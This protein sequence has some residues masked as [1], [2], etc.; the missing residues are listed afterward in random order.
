MNNSAR[1]AALTC[2][3]R[4]FPHRT[5]LWGVV[6]GCTEGPE[7]A[8][9]R[10]S[11]SQLQHHTAA[12]VSEEAHTHMPVILTS[13][14]HS[15]LFSCCDLPRVCAFAVH[16]NSLWKHESGSC[17]RCTCLIYNSSVQGFYTCTYLYKTSCF[18]GNISEKIGHNDVHFKSNI[19]LKYIYLARLC[20]SSNKL[21]WWIYH[22]CYYYHNLTLLVVPGL[23]FLDSTIICRFCRW[24]GF[25]DFVTGPCCRCTW[26][27][28]VVL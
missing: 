3:V 24:C 11:L 8:A 12:G 25:S 18:V 14:C 1:R 15:G 26:S 21:C 2:P 13:L 23:S 6:A 7:D 28:T 9:W 20:Y 5:D 19:F 4:F 16:F 17:E 10:Y 22:H 27:H